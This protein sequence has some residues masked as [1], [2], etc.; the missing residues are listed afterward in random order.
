[1][2]TYLPVGTSSK[3][4]PGIEKLMPS[5]RNCPTRFHAR[6]YSLKH[7]PS[8]A[9]KLLTGA[10]PQRSPYITLPAAVVPRHF[11]AGGCRF[12]P[13]RHPPRILNTCVIPNFNNHCIP[14][15]HSLSYLLIN[16]PAFSRYLWNAP[17]EH[18][19]NFSL[20]HI[21]PSY[22]LSPDLC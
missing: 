9:H 22:H 12:D 10:C 14:S 20:C 2:T 16:R 6:D 19:R 3:S 21:I 18:V 5:T 4:L 7:W 1:M 8:L 17:F 13:C 15:I 11:Y